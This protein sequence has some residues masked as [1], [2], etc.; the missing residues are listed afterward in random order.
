MRAVSMAPPI[1]SRSPQ[2]AVLTWWALTLL[3]RIT[4]LRRAALAAGWLRRLAAP[5]QSARWRGPAG[6]LRPTASGTGR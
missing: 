6:P 5:Q 1:P 2:L 3:V 4:R